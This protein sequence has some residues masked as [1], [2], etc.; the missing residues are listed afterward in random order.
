MEDSSNTS[1][2]TLSLLFISLNPKNT[3]IMRFTFRA[4]PK[5]N[6]I[7]VLLFSE[8]IGTPNPTTVVECIVLKFINCH[9]SSPIIESSRIALTC[10]RN[11]L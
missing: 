4:T 9:M 8:K 6:L 5:G 1:V 11:P 10:H 2:P 7:R 3:Y